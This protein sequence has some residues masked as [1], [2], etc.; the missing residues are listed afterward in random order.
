MGIS[1]SVRETT[2]RV[3]DVTGARNFYVMIPLEVGE[4]VVH[5][6]R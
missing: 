5:G 1:R 2:C 3:K 6:T 4:R